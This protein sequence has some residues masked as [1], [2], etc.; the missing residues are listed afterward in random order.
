MAAANVYHLDIKPG[1]ILANRKFKLKVCDFGLAGVASNVTQTESWPVCC[2]HLGANCTLFNFS[3]L[4]L[5]CYLLIF[6]LII[7][8]G[9]FITTKFYP[10]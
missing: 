7:I 4:L 5:Q 2:K 8:I 3:S 9:G 10:F 6:K 1:N